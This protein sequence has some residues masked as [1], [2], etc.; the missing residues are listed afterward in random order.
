M[1]KLVRVEERAFLGVSQTSQ[2]LLVSPRGNW[3]IGSAQAVCCA[4]N[5]KQEVSTEQFAVHTMLN[6]KS[7]RNSRTHTSSRLSCYIIPS[8]LGS[9]V[10]KSLAPP[11]RVTSG[12]LEPFRATIIFINRP[13]NGHRHTCRN[14]DTRE[15][16]SSL[17]T[18]CSRVL[19]TQLGA[20]EPGA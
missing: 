13:V 20:M 16:H 6:R 17:C 15:K 4:R 9:D 2:F 19:V 12:C 1:L 10:V 14:G 7:A 11:W 5:A 18:Q 3:S 8:L